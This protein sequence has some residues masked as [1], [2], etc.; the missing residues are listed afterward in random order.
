MIIRPAAEHELPKLSNLCLRSK[1]HWGYDTEFLDACREEL[2]LSPSELVATSVVVAES[3]TQLVG[4]AQVSVEGTDCD[5]LKLFVD[6]DHIG[7]GFGEALLKWAVQEGRRLGAQRMTIEADPEAEP[8]YRRMGAQTIGQVPSG[9]IP[10]RNLPLL[11]FQLTD[12]SP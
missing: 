7:R 2:T 4:I 5:L 1:A 11:A 10:G 9:S 3:G 12:A 6:P 8:F